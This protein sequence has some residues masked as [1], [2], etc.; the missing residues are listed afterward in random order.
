MHILSAINISVHF[1]AFLSAFNIFQIASSCRKNARILY[2]LLPYYLQVRQHKYKLSR[3]T[4]DQSSRP[5]EPATILIHSRI[6]I[7]R[8][9]FNFYDSVRPP[10]LPYLLK[11]FQLNH[12]GWNKT[13]QE[14]R[15]ESSRC[16]QVENYHRAKFR[17]ETRHTSEYR[18]DYLVNEEL[19]KTEEGRVQG[20]RLNSWVSG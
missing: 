2:D 1:T 6:Q 5:P 20:A 7:L 13:W 17:N 3:V 16:A 8:R 4:F 11:L 12:L 10:E 19:T 14:Q 15:V 9:N 18:R